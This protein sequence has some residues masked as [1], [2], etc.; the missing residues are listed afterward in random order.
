[1]TKQQKTTGPD[2]STRIR[3][4]TRSPPIPLLGA[5]N[6]VPAPNPHCIAAPTLPSPT[7][8]SLPPPPDT[9]PPLTDAYRPE[10]VSGHSSA[11][12]SPEA[13]YPSPYASSHATLHPSSRISHSPENTYPPSRNHLSA[14]G[15]SPTEP[16]YGYNDTDQAPSP[17]S[18]AGGQQPSVSPQSP[19]AFTGHYGL[20]HGAPAH[21]PS[22]A[23]IRSGD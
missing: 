20:Q 12:S 11:R 6:S 16:G 5:E 21:M 4:R 1:M 19:Y 10:S 23:H 3:P 2:L 22:G 13:S 14:F 9:P 7:I 15:H 17:A 8:N 18:S